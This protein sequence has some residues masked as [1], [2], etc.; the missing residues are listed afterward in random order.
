MI[1]LHSHLLPGVD[2]GAADLQMSVRMAEMAYADGIRG[3]VCT[4]HVMP[5]VYDN[6]SANII[7]AVAQLQSELERREIKLRLFAGADIHVSPDLVARIKNREIPTLARSRYFL[8]EPSHHVLTPRIEELAGR[9]I[10]AGI[11][12]IITHPERL[13]WISNH[14]NVFQR[15]NEL[16]CLVQITAASVTGEFGKY[17]KFYAEKL[18]DE[19]RVD[20][21]ATDA[22]DP[23]TRPPGLSKARD[24]V[25]ARLGDEEAQSMVLWRPANILS[26]KPVKPAGQPEN[27]APA[28][29]RPPGE[30]SVKDNFFKR[31]LWGNRT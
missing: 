19:R 30:E 23:V 29:E 27:S 5:G 21:L 17:A 7:P 31:F 14:Y 22:H 6:S 24:L 25:A 15:L 18:M 10:E 26:N 1:D 20:L 2:D 28:V 16:G 13:S 3:M 8:F 12:P 4:P 9:L 11:V